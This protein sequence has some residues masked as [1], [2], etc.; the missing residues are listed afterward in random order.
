MYKK[1]FVFIFF[2]SHLFS[3]LSPQ[4]SSLLK[5]KLINLGFL[6]QQI[7]TVLQE[8]SVLEKNDIPCSVIIT[9]FNEAEIK[10]IPYE[11]F[12]P[13]IKTYVSKAVTAKN[14][15][16]RVKSNKFQPKD[17]EYCINITIQVL[18]NGVN[19][20]EYIKIMTLLSNNYTFDDAV[21]MMNY[22]TVLKKYFSSPVVD[23]KNNKI[24]SP[25]EVLFLKYYTRPVTEMS[26][27]IQNV[28]NY[29]TI[30]NEVN[31]IYNVL[32]YNSHLATNKLVK[33]IKLL[34][35]K[36]IKQEV[37]NEVEQD[38]KYKKQLY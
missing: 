12:Y 35:N 5:Q 1:F 37:I 10:K 21:A 9:L 25:Y 4:L 24:S 32:Y 29:F 17:Y 2:T 38:K 16:D 26:V 13:V 36:K 11:K 34:C 33:Q 20:E 18:N 3:T 15:I 28:I 19:E 14:V 30:S 22:Y 7:D 6:Q 23:L 27:I 8:I 31:D